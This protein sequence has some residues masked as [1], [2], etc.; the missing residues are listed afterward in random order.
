MMSLHIAGAERLANGNTL[1]CEGE[2]GR[3]FEVTRDCEICWEWN[4][5]FVLEFK[6]IQAVMLFRSRRYNV[7]GPE[8]RGKKIDVKEFEEFNKK[9]NLNN[10]SKH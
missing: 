7:D 10:K 4:S 9:W 1:I 6:G 5:P 2:S 3:I 8:L